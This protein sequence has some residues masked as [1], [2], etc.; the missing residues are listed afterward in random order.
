MQFAFGRYS[1]FEPTGGTM[2]I[3]YLNPLSRGWERM[4]KA[5]FQ[6][7]DLKKWFVVGFTAFLAGL[8]DWHGGGGSGAKSRGRIDWDDVVYFPYKAWEWLLDNPGWFTLIVIGIFFTF[9]LVVL[10]T[11]LSSRGKFMFLDN[12]I[13]N[14]AQVI[15]PWYEYRAEGNS[16]FLWSFFIS[17]PLCF[18]RFRIPCG[19]SASNFWSNLARLITF[20]PGLRPAPSTKK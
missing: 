3:Q 2:S 10:F 19:R 13:H 15:N 12:V 11:W 6:P 8:T 7:F 20:S 17:T 14:R 1:Q 9:I 18:C 5:L 4:R 16:L